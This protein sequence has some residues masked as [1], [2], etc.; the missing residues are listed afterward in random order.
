MP[1]GYLKN[2]LPMFM[3]IS[4]TKTTL[5]NMTNFLGGCNPNFVFGIDAVGSSG[6]LV[7]YGWTA[8]DVSYLYVSPNIVLCKVVEPNGKIWKVMFIYGAP[9]VEDRDNVWI[10]IL[11]LLISSPTCLLIGD[12]NQVELYSDKLGGSSII[13]GWDEFVH[14]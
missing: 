3:F 7:V 11:N 4:E 14:W 9:N 8:F 10:Q 6:G 1:L 2:F 13:R 12:F 5:A